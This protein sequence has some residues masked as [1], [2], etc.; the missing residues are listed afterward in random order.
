MRKVYELDWLSHLVLTN[1]QLYSKEN[2]MTQTT[3]LDSIKIYCSSQ[4]KKQLKNIAMLENKNTSK[5]V[6]DILQEH[7]SQ[8]VKPNQEELM[9]IKKDIER[10]ELLTLTLFKEL[11]AALE[12]DDAFEEICKSIYRKDQ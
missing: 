11:Y 3:T 8:T 6:V 9:A 4:L 10:V 2:T 12:K 5:Y 1:Q 7:F